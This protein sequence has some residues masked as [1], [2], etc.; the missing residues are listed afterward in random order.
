MTIMNPK[1][2]VQAAMRAALL[3]LGVVAASDQASVVTSTTMGIPLTARYYRNGT[4][5]G[6]LERTGGSMH[7]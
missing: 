4:M 1:P 7:R 3:A 5:S 6:G 2:K